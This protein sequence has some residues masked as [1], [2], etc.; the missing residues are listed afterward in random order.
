MHIIFPVPQYNLKFCKD[1]FFFFIILKYIIH[2]VDKVGHDFD[3]AYA[4]TTRAQ[5]WAIFGAVSKH[6][7]VQTANSQ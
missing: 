6:F 1:N 4:D 5:I 2:T 3:C 7:H